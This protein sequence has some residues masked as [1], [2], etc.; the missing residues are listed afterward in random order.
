MVMRN[1]P[2]QCN[3]RAKS[4]RRQPAHRRDLGE[5]LTSQANRQRTLWRQSSRCHA[6]LG[7]VHPRT[8]AQ[9]ESTSRVDDEAARPSS[10]P[11]PQ[12]T[13][14]YAS[15]ASLQPHTPTCASAQAGRFEV[16]ARRPRHATNEEVRLSSNKRS[17]SSSFS[18]PTNIFT[19]FQRVNL[20]E[21]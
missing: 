13:R 11:R 1:N 7:Q 10:L 8:Q 21:L 5:G 4:H 9:C 15:C 19:L 14:R 16:P 17:D 18:R 3:I 6:R 2:R 20:R 12:S